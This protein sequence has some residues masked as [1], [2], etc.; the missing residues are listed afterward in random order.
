MGQKNKGAILSIIDRVS[1]SCILQKLNSKSSSEVS[2]KVVELLKLSKTP[3]LSITS[4]NGSEFTNHKFI[5]ENL[6][7][8]YYFAHPYASYKR[9]SIEN[10][11]G[12]VRQYLPK[13]TDFDSISQSKIKDIQ[14]KLNKQ[15]RKV[16]NFLSPLEYIDVIH[17]SHLNL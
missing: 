5:A 14:H 16:L 10:L 9:G 11:N 2:C 3:V 8:Q 15:P 4:D 13:G 7:V 17:I 6:G 12:L 1:R